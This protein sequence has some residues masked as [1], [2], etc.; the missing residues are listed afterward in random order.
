MKQ[1]GTYQRRQDQN[2]RRHKNPECG[3]ASGVC[4]DIASYNS[5]HQPQVHHRRI[6]SDCEATPLKQNRSHNLLSGDARKRTPN[7]R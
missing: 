4:R 5:G 1:P 6:A 3:N 2:E 7:L